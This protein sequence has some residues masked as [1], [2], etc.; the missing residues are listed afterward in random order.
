VTGTLNMADLGVRIAQLA[1]GDRGLV[2]AAA[3]ILATAFFAK[4]GAWPLNFWLVPAYSAAVSPVGAVFA[5]LTKLGIYT[6]LR[7]WTV[8]FAPDTGDVGRS[9][10][11]ACCRHRPGDAVRRRDRHRRHAAAV[12]PRRL[13]RAGL[14]RHA[15]RRHRPRPARRCGPARSTTC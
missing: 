9:S 8:L 11:R 10:A 2:H 5:L 14:G 6:I 1:P 15:A 13:Q 7:L 12:E 3:A 4:A